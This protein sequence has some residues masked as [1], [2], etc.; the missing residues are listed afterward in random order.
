MVWKLRKDGSKEA[1]WEPLI[2]RLSV[3]VRKAA[4]L[5]SSGCLWTFIL[6]SAIRISKRREPASLPSALGRTHEP[7]HL[8][9][10]RLAHG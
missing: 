5:A 3:N 7:T 10:S 8:L 4:P 1:K 6:E 9:L 2:L